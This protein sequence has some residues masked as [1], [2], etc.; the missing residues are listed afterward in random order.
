MN[1]KPASRPRPART[2][3]RPAPTH[4]KRNCAG[5]E[6]DSRGPH[7]GVIPSVI[8]GNMEGRDY[9]ETAVRQ[10]T[11]L[12]SIELGIHG[13]NI[14]LSKFGPPH[15]NFTTAMHAAI[16]TGLISPDEYRDLIRANLIIYGQNHHHAVVETSLGPD[17]IDRVLRRSG[18]LHTTTGEDVV[19]VIATPHPP[20]SHSTSRSKERP[21]PRQHDPPAGWQGADGR[22]VGRAAPKRHNTKQN[23]N[24][25][26]RQ[27]GAEAAM[28]LP[29]PPLFFQ[30]INLR[31]WTITPY[32]P[33]TQIV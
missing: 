25:S 3:P 30:T 11:L 2:R 26:Q 20:S 31:E 8:L 29:S 28:D 17:D 27:T 14:V 23:V 32:S 7:P 13:P 15:P 6:A 33:A 4:W 19:P 22:A 21:R 12:A 10:V 1:E 16:D 9:E 24:P 18:I 5:S